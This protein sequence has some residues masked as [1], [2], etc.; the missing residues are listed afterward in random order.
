ML[1]DVCS[2]LNVSV[3]SLSCAL[4]PIY[5]SVVVAAAVSEI[6]TAKIVAA[7]CRSPLGYVW[8]PSVGLIGSNLAYNFCRYVFITPL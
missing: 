1:C 4:L 5:M 2:R 8:G 7:F 6:Y 3:C